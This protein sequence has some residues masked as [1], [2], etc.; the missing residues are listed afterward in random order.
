[1]K[2]KVKLSFYG[3]DKFDD[4]RIGINKMLKITLKTFMHEKGIASYKVNSLEYK[5]RTMTKIVGT[6]LYHGLAE[7]E[8]KESDL[9]KGG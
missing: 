2:Q 1:M 4:N 7:V 5:E 6:Y 8:F 3:P 9:A